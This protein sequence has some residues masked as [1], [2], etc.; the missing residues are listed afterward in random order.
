MSGKIIIYAVALLVVSS[1]AQW[2]VLLSCIFY[3]I[4]KGAF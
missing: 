3:I 2:A 4:G 1:V